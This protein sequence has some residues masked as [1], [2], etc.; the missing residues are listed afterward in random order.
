MNYFKEK[1]FM[2]IYLLL[3]ILI[4]NGNAEINKNTKIWSTYSVTISEKESI[5]DI[6]K[7]L[8]LLTQ[9]ITYEDGHRIVDNEKLTHITLSD[10]WSFTKTINTVTHLSNSQDYKEFIDTLQSR[11]L[12]MPDL[13]LET[14]K[15]EIIDL[16]QI[17]KKDGVNTNNK[18]F[19]ETIGIHYLQ[20]KQYYQLLTL[21]KSLEKFMPSSHYSSSL[22]ILINE[23]VK[24]TMLV[25]KKY[26]SEL[27][28]NC[29]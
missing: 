5:K 27:V 3:F 13:N 28:H 24:K 7:K 11:K 16:V 9:K 21:I 20:G 26:L 15:K 10:M 1:L 12:I 2:P 19:L 17:M 4:T 29:N 23:K 8:R 25:D 6:N 18:I 22:R 14:E